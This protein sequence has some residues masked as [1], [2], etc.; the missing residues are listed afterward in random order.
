MNATAIKHVNS[1]LKNLPDALVE[2]VEKYIDFLAFKYSQETQDVP[3]WH[4]D[5]VLK[6]IK[7]NKEPVDA[8]GML[9][10]LEA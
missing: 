5:V 1:K 6:R 7:D 3:Q 2:E 10:N 4:K 8:F 9:N